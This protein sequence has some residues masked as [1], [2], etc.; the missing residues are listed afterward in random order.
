MKKIVHQVPSLVEYALIVSTG[1]SVIL[2][3]QDNEVRVASVRM[4]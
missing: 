2:I 1:G 4:N 3:E